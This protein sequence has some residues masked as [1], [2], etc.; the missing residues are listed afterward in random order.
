[1][2]GLQTTAVGVPSIDLDVTLGVQMVLFILLW[3]FLR[4][5]VFK[6]YLEAFRERVVLTEEARAKAEAS[7]ERADDLLREYESKLTA[8]RQE[9]SDARSEIA[10]E[11]KDKADEI[12][13]EARTWSSE[14]IEDSRQK[15]DDE[16]S[17]AREEIRPQAES[18][19][20]AIAQKVLA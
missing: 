5:T 20:D 14:H 9:A 2:I 10:N 17:D 15:L 16:L 18:L 19:S 6:P 12:I 13:G 11:G 1:M 3:M 7:Q 8:A 4:A